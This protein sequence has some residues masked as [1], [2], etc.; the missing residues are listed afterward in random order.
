L[1]RTPAVAYDGTHGF[2][3]QYLIELPLFLEYAAEAG[4]QADPRF[5]FKFPNSDI[6]TVSL[7]FFT[8]RGA[9]NSAGH[10]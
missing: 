8:A 9:T 1:D 7:S 2:S 3:D 5:Q 4:L 6:A 10:P